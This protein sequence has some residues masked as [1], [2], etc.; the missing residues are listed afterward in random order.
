[1]NELDT[2]F[3]RLN[4]C[5][6]NEN[7]SSA[8]LLLRLEHWY[9]SKLISS[10]HEWSIW[11]SVTELW[12]QLLLVSIYSRNCSPKTQEAIWKTTATN[13]WHLVNNRNAAR[14][15]RKRKYEYQCIDNNEDR[16]RC[17]QTSTQQHVSVSIGH[18]LKTIF[19][20]RFCFSGT[21]IKYMIW[22]K[23]LLNNRT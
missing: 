11:K 14:S 12:K 8:W 10:C 2:R 5:S 19:H 22:W 9:W 23:I 21:S 20:Q 6:W 13:R 7:D 17:T 1:M 16:F 15:T 4:I 3:V 18:D